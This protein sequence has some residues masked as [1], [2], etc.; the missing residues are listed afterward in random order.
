MKMELLI[1]KKRDYILVIISEL[2]IQISS[3]LLVLNIISG[4][5]IGEIIF[6]D[7]WILLFFFV[8]ALILRGKLFIQ[9]SMTEAPLL[10]NPFAYLLIFFFLFVSVFLVNNYVAYITFGF[11]NFH[12]LALY[13]QAM[14]NFVHGNGF[15]NPVWSNNLLGDHSELILIPLSLLYIFWQSPLFLLYL[16]SIAIAA[17]I[18]PL[19]F[20]SRQKLGSSF[21]ALIIC[22]LYLTFP[23]ILNLSVWVEFRPIVFAIPIVFT[24]FYFYDKDK[25]SIFVLLMLVSTLIKETMPLVMATTGLYILLLSRKKSINR[26]TGLI[27]LFTGTA[28]FFFMIKV[29]IPFYRGAPF[30]HFVRLIGGD[31]IF[32]SLLKDPMMLFRNGEFLS[33][34]KI[35][36]FLSSFY[37]TGFIPF[38]SFIVLIPLSSWAQVLLSPDHSVVGQTW[39]NT[40]I[41]VFMFISLIFGI[42]NLKRIKEV[43]ARVALFGLLLSLIISG[44]PAFRALAL[45]PIISRGVFV[46]DVNTKK[47]DDLKS[48]LK[49]IPKDS[50]IYTTFRFLPYVS[51]REEVY[52]YPKIERWSDADYIL[53]APGTFLEPAGEK[54]LAE[55]LNSGLYSRLTV[56]GETEVW[57]RL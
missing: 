33:S 42:V 43:L 50:A 39:H 56:V 23:M 37:R 49:S 16:Q 41:I 30:D 54:K 25:R 48:A 57:K 19:F 9:C 3:M 51:S 21:W 18:F 27:L 10:S 34:G 47:Y 36:Y 38:F 29:L 11:S 22:L 1:D 4:F 24:A 44:L 15:V 12:D 45:N 26:V 13:N 7:P 55:A 32:M 46:Q 20:L 35:Q 17:A 40:P 31:N 5:Q 2:I 52:W 53:F 6:L 28:L 8:S 14:Y